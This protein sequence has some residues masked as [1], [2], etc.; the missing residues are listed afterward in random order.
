VANLLQ[1]HDVP[2]VQEGELT[3]AASP[4]TPTGGPLQVLL[5]NDR[6][7]GWAIAPDAAATERPFRCAAMPSN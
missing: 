5:V 1:S 4:A 3:S 6:S 2:V 7:G